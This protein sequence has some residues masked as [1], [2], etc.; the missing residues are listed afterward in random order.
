VLGQHGD[1]PPAK[2]TGVVSVVSI[3]EAHG[4]N[5]SSASRWVKEAKRQEANRQGRV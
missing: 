1:D 5:K 4:V 2:V 3:A